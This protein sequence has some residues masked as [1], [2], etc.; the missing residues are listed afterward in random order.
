MKILD[1]YIFKKFITA[2]FFG[3]GI[4]VLLAVVFD[5]SEKVED[6]QHEDL[7]WKIIIFTYYLNF[8]PYFINLLSPLFIF[9][10]VIFFTANLAAKS[11]IV[12]ILAG[13]MS[14]YRLLLPYM[15]AAIVLAF[16]S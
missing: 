6:F 12:A 4:F 11:E 9:I 14:F 1:L 8:I 5:Y 10:S 2:F 7:N 13:G 3:I 16:M 15:A